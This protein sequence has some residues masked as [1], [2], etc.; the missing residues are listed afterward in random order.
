MDNKENKMKE[1]NME[2]MEMI[3]GGVYNSKISMPARSGTG[4]KSKYLDNT[5]F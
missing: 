3:T 2:Q 5:L 1:L 4:S